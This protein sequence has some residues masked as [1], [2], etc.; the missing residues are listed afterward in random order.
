MKNNFLFLQLLD[1]LSFFFRWFNV[2]YP[3]FRKI[4]Q[5]K[6]MMDQRRVST[7]LSNSSKKNREREGGNNFSKSLIFYGLIGLIMLPF[8]FME[9]QY[10]F[11]MS[12]IFAILSF[13]VMTTLI[14]EFSSVL[15]DVRDKNILFSKPV[16]RKT[17]NMAK[18]FHIIYYVLII[19]FCITGPSLIVAL[20][21]HGVLFFFLFL[22]EIIIISLLIIV[23]TGLVYLLVLKF[24]DG[25]KLKDIINYVQIIL[26][27]VL[28]VGYQLV[29]RLFVLVDKQ[30]IFTP[31][32]WQFFIFPVWFGAP[33]EVLLN[34]N[35]TSLLIA[36]SLLAFV[37]PIGAIL[38]YIKLMPSFEKNMQ[39]LL[40]NQ[41]KSKGR[42]YKFI[43]R[44]S[45]LLCASREE[46]IFFKFAYSMM[47]REREFK[48]KIYPSLGFSLV[49]PFIFLANSLMH[50]S[51]QDVV[52]GKLYY[53][54][55]F[56]A[57][58]VP[59]M[60]M[61]IKFSEKYQG[62]WLYKTTPI[63]EVTPIFKGVFKAFLL[64]LFIPVYCVVSIS[65]LFIFGMR[66]IP[67]LIAVLLGILLYV[68][69]CF[70]GMKQSL[71][72]SKKFEVSSQGQGIIGFFLML[73]VGVLAGIHFLLSF[74]NYGIYIYICLLLI[75]NYVLWRK[76]FTMSWHKVID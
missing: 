30:L 39:K 68:V 43:N 64:K 42:S 38:I 58:I 49:F 45:K 57:F 36:F 40:N 32:W 1:R 72:F 52:N 10:F 76:G 31:K 63:H 61:M 3:A 11:Q 73:L 66:I 29:G 59:S 7:V 56:C 46:Q 25:E 2:D 33:F 37:V 8:I 6:L 51:Y 54:S 70:K 9:N 50:D 47:R 71:P 74:I 26:S 16:S 75:C 69:I 41:A 28:A 17:I 20:I 22:I 18:T 27:I 21:K 44:V 24:F 4:L 35:T 65:Y 60:I 12:M 48:L 67:D 14:S 23:L 34:H 13:L 62:S 19:T 5:V 15:L 55:Y 53:N